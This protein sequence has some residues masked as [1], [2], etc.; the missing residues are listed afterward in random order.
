V[1][2]A[3][4]RGFDAARFRRM[5]NAEVV[6]GAI[7]WSSALPPFWIP[8]PFGSFLRFDLWYFVFIV[9]FVVL[10]LRRGYTRNT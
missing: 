7:F 3:R 2:A 9:F 8:D 5:M 1:L 6:S 10:G 4:H